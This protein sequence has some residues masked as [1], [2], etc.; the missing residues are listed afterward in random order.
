MMEILLKG[1]GW[2]VQTFSDGSKR[3]V[4]TTLNQDILRTYGV[5]AK[6]GY[7]F[8][9]DSGCY[10]PVRNDACDIEIFEHRPV[11]KDKGVNDFVDS[12]ILGL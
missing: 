5:T 12:F 10:Y 9:L 3:V 2:V 8:N 4:R 7:L 6:N 1:I 11:F